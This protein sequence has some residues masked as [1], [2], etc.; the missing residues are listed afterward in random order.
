ME[1]RGYSS[2]YIHAIVN[3]FR[4]T[5]HRINIKDYSQEQ[6]DVWAPADV[7]MV[8]WDESF[9]AHTSVVAIDR[10]VVVG[11]G[12]I[13]SSGYIDRLYVHADYQRQGIATAICDRLESSVDT[14]RITVH[15]SIT[16]R[17]FFEKRGYRT[18]RSQNVV[19]HG[20]LLENYVMEL[21]LS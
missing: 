14:C 13:D 4:D 10:G 12:D 8:A 9:K 3:L 11:F 5:V 6:V 17:R 19:R 1:I 15:A 16:A 20:V 2:A 21:Q 7:D 18:V